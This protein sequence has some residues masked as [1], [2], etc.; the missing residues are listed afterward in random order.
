VTLP[1]LERVLDVDY[2]YIHLLVDD[3][4]PPYLGVPRTTIVS[5]PSPMRI[6][7]WGST[8][9]GFTMPSGSC[10]SVILMVSI[11]SGFPDMLC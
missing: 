4:T 5:G 11:T 1:P 6:G 7:Y 3:H 8:S 2:H 9:I 10:Q